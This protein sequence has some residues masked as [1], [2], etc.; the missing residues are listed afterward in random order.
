MRLF[1]YNQNE[2]RNKPYKVNVDPTMC[3]IIAVY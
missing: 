1:N 2:N 3:S